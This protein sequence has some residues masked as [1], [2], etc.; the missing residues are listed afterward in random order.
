MHNIDELIKEYWALSPDSPSGL[1]YIKGR[2]GSKHKVG[3]PACPYLDSKGYY[4]GGLGRRTIK[5]HRAVYFLAHGCWPT[6]IDHVDGNRQNNNPENLREVT[7]LEN[8]HNRLVRGYYKTR[9]GKYKAVIRCGGKQIRLGEFSTEAEAR[10]AYLTAKKEL[11]PT[12]PE[13]CYA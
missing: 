10:T 9:R 11:H 12:A 3:D 5:A 2:Q 4:V 13:R 8:N 1:V 7:H 6:Y